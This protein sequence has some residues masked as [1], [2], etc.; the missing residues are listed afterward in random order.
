MNKTQISTTIFALFLCFSIPSFGSEK[1]SKSDI[2]IYLNTSYTFKERAADLVSRLTLEEKQG[3]L[4]N[5]MPAI[6]RVGINSYNVWGEALHGISAFF[7]PY[8]GPC[9]SFPG[10]VA[11]GSA[12]DPELMERETK[13]IS[14]EGRGFNAIAINNLTFW[15][16]V[17][18]PVRD[19]RWGRTGE[20]FGEDPF[21]VSQI[22]SGFIRGMMGNDPVYYKT[23]PTAK[24]YFA[25][26]SEF[27]R[28][29]GTSNMDDRD[30]REY[31]LVPYKNLIEKDRLPSI[32]T[33][34]NSVNNIPVTASK[35]LVDSIAK[36]TYGL[37]GYVTSD[38][39]GVGDIQTGHFYAKTNAEA[40]AMGLKAGVDTDCGNVYQTGTLNALNEGLITE[41]DMDRALLNI[42]TIRMK[43]GEFDPKNEVPYSMIQ[44][45]VVNAPAHV[46]LAEEVATKTPVL[47]KNSTMEE[48]EKILP[49]NSKKLKKIALIGPQADKV[50]LGPYSGPTLPEN[51][52]TPLAGIKKYLKD[53]DSDIELAYSTGA[54]TVSYSNLYYVSNFEIVKSDGSL[55][56][57]DAS[58]YSSAA[59]G[60]T[61]GSGFSGVQSVRSIKQGDWTSYDNV[62]ISD[63]A[64]MNINVNI[65]GDGGIIDVRVG[66]TTGNLL[67]SFE[68]RGEG[69]IMGSMNAKVFSADVHKLGI[70][71]SQTIYLVYRGHEPTSIDE[72]T[73]AMAS[74]ADVALVFVGTDDNTA[75]EEA[76][77]L[78]LVL[79]GNQ[80]QLIKAVAEVNKN[81][82]VVMQTLGMVEVDQFK[83][84]PN[85]KGIIWTGFNGQAQGAAM[86]RILFGDVNPGGKLNATWYKSLIDLP[87]I[88]DYNLRGGADKNG[89]TY[90]YFD[91]EVSYE[92]GYGLSYTNFSYSNFKI[93]KSSITPNDKITISVDVRNTG[94]TDGDEIV[95]IY[96]RTP[97]SP[98]SMQRPAKRLKG[99]QRVTIPT[100]QIK[101]VNIDID[102]ADLWFWDGATDR[103]TFDQGRY[104]FEIAASS[105]DVR[106]TVEATMKGDFKP[107]LKTVV[108]ECDHI[109][110]R[111]GNTTQTR[112]SAAMTDDSFYDIGKAA[113]IYRS[114]N[115]GVASV[116]ELGMVTAK[117]AGVATISASVT[118]DGK[119]VTNSYPLKVMPNLTLASLLV[120]G[121]EVKGFKP[122]VRGYSYLLNADSKV[123]AIT[124][125]QTDNGVTLEIEQ[126]ESIPG[127]AV[128]T[129]SDN[130]TVEK[131]KYVV[132]FATKSVSDEFKGSALGKQ[133]NWVR[134]NP[135]NWS[136]SK[137]P[138]SLLITA[139]KGDI[140]TSNN[141]AE[142]ILLQSANSDWTIETELS[143]SK[144]LTKTDQQGGILVYQDDDNYVKLVY[145][146][147]LKGF[148]GVGEYIELIVET[149]GAQV[150]AANFK[151]TN[152]PDK[153]VEIRF[154]LVKIGCEYAAYYSLDGKAYQFLG[155]T[156][157][158]LT[159]TQAGLV[160][161][162]GMGLNGR[163]SFRQQNGDTTPLE[164]TANYFRIKSTGL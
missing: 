75:N 56:Q 83:D 92:F 47:L 99:F 13:V 43:L 85:V 161:C 128:I 154:K 35:F 143:F 163:F 149:N 87:D 64:K 11:L 112:V 60:I 31:Y 49:L 78:T 67:A 93:N 52:I 37:D 36:K 23:V 120:N 48:G 6:P 107:E 156:E 88:T 130:G 139:A 10:S 28:H 44:Q 73:L 158:L 152:L 77:R 58:K 110:M 61:I 80:Y 147:A 142:N 144:R 109:V 122:G 134:E 105:K 91:K 137:K 29:T 21:L 150:S 46:A 111:Q 55:H 54:N 123:P 2:P 53:R 162:D 18:E 115:P 32:M 62:D 41:A 72:Q 153:D 59:D 132:N 25:N 8:A 24:H 125:S 138:G 9:T 114:N 38:C 94:D 113:I 100:G 40:A 145:N 86:A 140:M 121:S 5:T 30:M 39:G 89:R 15:S 14:E 98:A 65:P 20:S 45:S 33:C 133:W 90:W 82:V 26:N 160:V 129:L 66:S 141:N 69:G 119:T 104:I 127:S 17:V 74:S 97:D 4:G 81:T 79:P 155:E 151:P 76:D 118:I 117:G 27:N 57:Y 136:L 12:W 146:N 148:S 22:A 71:G 3:L 96:M 164:V 102:C 70:S 63:A 50:E 84:I 1:E 51:M 34:Y 101:T 7:N 124:A 108:A 126:A 19:P 95:Q 159:N 16:P 131:D 103:I 42:F 68:V 106:G 157:S 116:D 135:E